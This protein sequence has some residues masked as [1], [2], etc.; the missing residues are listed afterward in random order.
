MWDAR[1]CTHRRTKTNRP[2]EP[3][4]STPR[5][6]RLRSTLIT[7]DSSARN[8]FCV[9]EDRTSIFHRMAPRE[10]LLYTGCWWSRGTSI[11]RI[12][13][14]GIYLYF[15]LLEIINLNMLCD[16]CL[17]EEILIRIYCKTRLRALFNNKMT[18]CGKEKKALNLLLKFRLCH[19]WPL[20]NCAKTTS[21]SSVT[22]STITTAVIIVALS[23]RSTGSNT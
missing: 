5:A 9:K 7:A 10:I 18:N 21:S 4:G 17:T 11:F 8:A 12:V 23:T 6:P 2:G 13:V 22:I 20:H 19:T 16:F 1:E 15:Y 3:G 14:I